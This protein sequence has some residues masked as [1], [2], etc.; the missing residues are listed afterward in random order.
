[1]QPLVNDAITGQLGQTIDGQCEHDAYRSDARPKAERAKTEPAAGFE[2]SIAL[3][4]AL[5]KEELADAI[6]CAP[7]RLALVP[8]VARQVARLGSW[9][10]S[11]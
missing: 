6:I 3:V 8:R 11:S 4:D 10:G 1:M 5:A 2:R 9:P 7:G